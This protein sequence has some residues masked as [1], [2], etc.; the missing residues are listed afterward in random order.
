MPYTADALRRVIDHI[1]EVQETLGRT[2]LLENPSTYVAFAES[3]YAEGEFIAAVARATGCGLLL[4]VNNLY[5]SSVNHGTS[6]VGYLNSYPL[7]AVREIHLAG[8]LRDADDDGSPLLID[9]HDR[10]VDAPVWQLF[11]EVLRRIGPTPAL[12]EWDTRVPPF[13]NLA[14]QANLAD[15][16]IAAA[17]GEP[18]NAHLSRAG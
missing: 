6:P 1:D 16:L 10:A 13:S 12:I 9:T 4:D 18:Y 14:A 17:E 11:S 3:T 5:V 15:A 7:S 2:I 8:H